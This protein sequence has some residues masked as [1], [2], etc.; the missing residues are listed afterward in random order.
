MLASD[1]LKI[2]SR[3][4]CDLYSVFISL[5]SHQPFYIALVF[6]VSFSFLVPLK[7]KC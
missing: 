7:L 2:E 1:T 6:S 3:N 4:G 5:C